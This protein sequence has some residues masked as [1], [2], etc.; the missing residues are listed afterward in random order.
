MMNIHKRKIFFILLSVFILFFL[1]NFFILKEKGILTIVAHPGDDLLYFNPDIYSYIKANKKITTVF[2]TSGDAGKD[3]GYWQN[4]ENGIK[5]AYSFMAG[6][7]NNW[8]E[9][10]IY[11]N[12]SR[13]FK[14]TL[15]KNKKINLIVLRLPDGNFEGEGYISNGYQTLIKLWQNK[16]ESIQ[17]VDKLNVYDK[18]DL[19][20]L[21]EKII[22]LDNPEIINIQDISNYKTTRDHSDHYA[23]AYFSLNAIKNIK[24]NNQIKII[25]YFGNIIDSYEKN[26]DKRDINIKQEIFFIYLKH[27]LLAKEALR[28]YAPYLDRQYKKILK[29]D[30]IKTLPPLYTYKNEILNEKNHTPVVLK[31]VTTQFFGYHFYDI[32]TFKKKYKIFKNKGIN[33][34]GAFITPFT[35]NE[36]IEY[37]DW[38]V[39]ETEKDHI[40]LYLTPTIEGRIKNPLTYT[41]NFPEFISQIS[42]RYKNKTHI[43]Y[44]VW[45]EPH[46]I[47]WKEYVE[48]INETIKK[49]RYYQP[50]ALILVNGIDWGSRF[51]DIKD[52]K[53]F[54]NIILDFH[55][56]PSANKKELKKYLEN[57]RLEFPWEKFINQFPIIIG[58]FGGVWKQDFSSEEDLKFINLALNNINKNKLSY[59][60]YT[61]DDE[62]NLNLIDHRSLKI[63]KKGKLLIEDIKKNPPTYL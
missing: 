18:N 36:K 2:M 20:R 58:E 41:K 45:A 26:L 29:I 61:L 23:T 7:D 49:I 46:N 32:S 30:N 53:Q 47:E 13:I 52:L 22:A 35:I 54:E 5:E 43:M 34:I 27:D 40:Y 60:F 8:H 38:L 57:S 4:L 56:Y 25:S 48:M 14:Y 62:D 39:N 55:Y 51:Y 37:I 50:K 19:I 3:S 11:L 42:K 12:K 21:I 15:S 6:K 24:K 31:G 1:N 59:T 63:T 9:K 33:L 17:T 16:I 44:G 28:L 10:I